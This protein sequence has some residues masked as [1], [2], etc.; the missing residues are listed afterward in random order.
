M[1]PGAA[2]LAMQ[3]PVAVG[4]RLDVQ[5]PIGARLLLAVGHARQQALALDAAV[6][7]GVAGMYVVPTV[8]CVAETG[9]TPTFPVTV[10][11]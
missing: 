1:G 5:K 10:E 8:V 9:I 4:D 2:V 11:V 3:V 7:D 6:D